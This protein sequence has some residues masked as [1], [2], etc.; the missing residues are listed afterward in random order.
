MSVNVYSARW[1]ATFHPDPPRTLAEAE[2]LA[3]RLPLPAF[4]RVLDVCCGRGRHA[5]VL[6]AVGYAVTG[7]DRDVE[8]LA[9]AAQHTPD[10]RFVELDVRELAT[11]EAEFDA[12]VSLWQSFGF[13]TAETNAAVLAAM[14]ERV[15]PGGRVVLDVFDR[16]FFEANPEPRTF[17]AAVHETRTFDGPR[18]RVRLEYGDGA[19]EFEW[20]VYTP[21]E[22][23]A[24]A[25]E[26]GLRVLLTSSSFSEDARADG[27]APRFQVVLERPA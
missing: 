22:L 16:R 11:L 25:E 8:A 7:V 21:D 18:M 17:D 9:A 12:A 4:R 10:A 24:L 14:R 20:H 19:D 26:L 1:R 6:Q 23:A 5:A 15:R 27:S 13:F 3:R 2:F